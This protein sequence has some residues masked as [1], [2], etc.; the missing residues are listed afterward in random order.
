MERVLWVLLIDNWPVC[1]AFSEAVFTSLYSH[2]QGASPRS[3]TPACLGP[4]SRAFL[5]AGHGAPRN[6]RTTIELKWT[7]RGSSV[8][9]PRGYALISVY[10]CTV[11][12]QI[13]EMRPNVVWSGA[14]TAA[15]NPASCALFARLIKNTLLFCVVHI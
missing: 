10:T 4:S 7:T 15:T 13:P 8:G 6:S 3:S 1:F 9:N 14:K 11:F 2:K 5:L 12:G